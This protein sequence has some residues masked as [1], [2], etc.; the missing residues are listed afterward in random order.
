MAVVGYRYHLGPLL[1][2]LTGDGRFWILALSQNR[3]RLFEATRDTVRAIDA[4]DIPSGLTDV[5]GYDWEQRSLQFH[6]GASRGGGGRKPVIFHGHGGGNED[7]EVERFV[8]Q[9]ATAVDRLVPDRRAPL[10]VAAVDE[11]AAAFRKVSRYPT[12][13]EEHLSGNPDAENGSDLHARAWPVVEP[14]FNNARSK[15]I[16]RCDEQ[17]GVGNAP[18]ELEPLVVAATEGRVDTL[19]IADGTQ[20][21]GRFDVRARTVTEHSDPRPGDE[22]LVDRAAIDTIRHSGTVYVLPPEQVPGG[23]ELTGLLR[24]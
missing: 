3:V 5:V 11:L 19:F 12:L 18:C 4:E 20:R 9:V 13:I 8:R 10:V 1:S 24:Y 2:L 22:D 21:W 17:L 23:L 16:A 14:H 6:G 15:A 7:V